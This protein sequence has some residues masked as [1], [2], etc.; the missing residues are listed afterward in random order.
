MEE[1][2]L[3]CLYN[4]YVKGKF[5]YRVISNEYSLRIKKF[6][7]EPSRNPFESKKAQLRKFFRLV[8]DLYKKGYD[9]PFKGLHETKSSYRISQVM[10]RNLRRRY[11]DFSPN[12]SYNYYYLKMRGGSLVSVI[13]YF[14][15]QIIKRKIPLQSKQKTLIKEILAWCK[16]KQ[17]Y[18]LSVI[19]ISRES[20]QL[21]KARINFLKGKYF[22]S[23]FGSFKNFK[24]VILEKGLKKYGPFLEK[25][26]GFYIRIK[27][28]IPSRDIKILR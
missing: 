17:R 11:L 10:R 20:K 13:S 18:S 25:N 9:I 8:E 15:N 6:G 14:A 5:I 1:K 27:C 2:E 23:P 24:K 3:A 16:I 21:E 7:L 22:P 19:K 26:K 4:K 28:K 12:Y